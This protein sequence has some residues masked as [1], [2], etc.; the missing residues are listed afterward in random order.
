MEKDK[1]RLVSYEEREWPSTAL[2]CPQ[3][4]FSYHQV[5]TPGYFIRLD[6][7]GQAFTYHTNRSSTV[8]NCTPVG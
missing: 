5:V 6:I 2:G 4:G 3:P 8:I 7:E 1:V